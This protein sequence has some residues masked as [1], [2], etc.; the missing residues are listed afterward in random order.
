MGNVSK[1]KNSVIVAAHPDDEVLWF[2]SILEKVQQII[3]CFSNELAD[4]NFGAR[5]IKSISN[6]PMQNVSCLGLSS[7]G[8]WR[9]RSFETPIFNQYGLEFVGKNNTHLTD[10]DIYLKNYYEL[11][12]KL[13]PILSQYQNIFTHN[14][15]GEYGHEEHVQVYRVVN[16]LQATINFNL[17]YSNYCST[18]TIHIVPQYTHVEE[19]ITFPAKDNIVKKLVNHYQ[20]Y[21]VWTWEKN[22]HWPSEETFIKQKSHAS[23]D[24]SCEEEK[25]LWTRNSA[26]P[27]NLILMRPIPQKNSEQNFNMFKRLKVFTQRAIKKLASSTINTTRT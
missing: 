20:D 16:E 27:L 6:S 24:I 26:V 5:R 9:P 21:K 12:E 10:K 19:M 15:W 2:S 1:L 11:K 13:S 18:R 17:W 22:W 8:V 25:H 4:P 23:A 3:I 14:P 7:L